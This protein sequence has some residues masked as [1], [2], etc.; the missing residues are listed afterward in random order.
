MSRDGRSVLSGGEDKTMRLWD[1]AS[2]AEKRCLRGHADSVRTVAFVPDGRRAVSGSHDGTV[3]L[4]DLETGN[5]LR[6]YKG[7]TDVV[8]CAAVS[9][10]G[11][12]IAAAGRDKIDPDLGPG[13]RRAVA[14][15]PRPASVTWLAFSPDG[16]RLLSGGWSWAVRLWDSGHRRARAARSRAIALRH[17]REVLPRRPPRLSSSYDE[18]IRLWQLPP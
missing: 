8:H 5:E 3:R 12:R 6:R 16:R 9:P 18:T 17:L 13:E 4:W 11:R 2:R 14:L 1:F 15:A 7:N 10:D